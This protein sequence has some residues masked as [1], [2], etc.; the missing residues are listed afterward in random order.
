MEAVYG[1]GGWVSPTGIV[2][3]KLLVALRDKSVDGVGAPL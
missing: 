3:M 1:F 2:E